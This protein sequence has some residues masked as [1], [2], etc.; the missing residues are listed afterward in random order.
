MGASPVVAHTPTGPFAS[1]DTCRGCRARRVFPSCRSA[2][3]RRQAFPRHK[4][5]SG[6]WLVGLN[7]RVD[8]RGGELTITSAPGTGTPLTVT[9]PLN[10]LHAVWSSARKTQT[11]VV[12]P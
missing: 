3:Q 11:D 4:T 10:T 8:A 5:G 2:V 6:S 9:I 1:A 7:D 12:L